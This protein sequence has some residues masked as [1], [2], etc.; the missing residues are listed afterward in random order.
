MDDITKCSG[1]KDNF[2]CPLREKCLRYISPSATF[3]SYFMHMPYNET[4]GKCEHL[5][6]IKK[7]N[8]NES[9]Y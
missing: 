8:P 4:E 3:Q 2:N 7:G 9:E 6:S 1:V 5:I